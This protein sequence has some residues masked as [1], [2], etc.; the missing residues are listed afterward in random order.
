MLSIKR[1]ETILVALGIALIG[2]IIGYNALYISSPAET[3]V[4][5][6][7][8]N[9]ATQDETYTPQASG[10]IETIEETVEKSTP[11]QV[12]NDTAQDRVTVV[13]KNSKINLNSANIEELQQLDGIGPSKA[14]AIIDYRESKG[15][16]SSVDE[17]AEVKGIGE[18]T[19]EKIRIM[20]TV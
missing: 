7:D 15:G 2:I 17:L 19:L 6:E 20:L 18:K 5:Y 12:E 3:V 10:E 8:T 14:Q 1:Q 16:F 4:I 11:A 13:D 9:V